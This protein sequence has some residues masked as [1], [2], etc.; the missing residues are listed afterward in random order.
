[1]SPLVSHLH[2]PTV[3]CSILASSFER[4]IDTVGCIERRKAGPAKPRHLPCW[5]ST[6]L[7]EWVP[8]NVHRITSLSCLISSE[9]FAPSPTE[10]NLGP[11]AFS[12]CLR[13]YISLCYFSGL[14]TQATCSL[15]LPSWFSLPAFSRFM[16]SHGLSNH[17]F[18]PCVLAL[19]HYVI[20]VFF[21][22]C[23]PH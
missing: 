10:Q 4:E 5:L 7:P 19:T 17:L 22:T 1:M 14:A 2:T 16:P 15:S 6:P 20:A 9:L 3:F 18:S 8:L 13:S 12:P 23:S 21:L 11:S